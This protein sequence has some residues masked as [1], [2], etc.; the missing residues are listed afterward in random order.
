[1]A[2]NVNN[3]LSENVEMPP[4]YSL[5]KE[6]K[7]VVDSAITMTLTSINKDKDNFIGFNELI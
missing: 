1:M 2:T 4:P 5:S 7:K 3:R 6:I